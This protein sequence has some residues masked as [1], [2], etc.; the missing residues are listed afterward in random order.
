MATPTPNTI[1]TDRTGNQCMPPRAM[2]WPA[3]VDGWGAYR[4]QDLRRVSVPAHDTLVVHDVVGLRNR[5]QAAV[6]AIARKNGVSAH[7]DPVMAWAHAGGRARATR[8]PSRPFHPPARPRSSGPARTSPQSGRGISSVWPQ[9]CQARWR[10][11]TFVGLR[12]G[13]HGGSVP[14][15]A[16]VARGAQARTRHRGC[17][18]QRKS[19]VEPPAGATTTAL[20][21]AEH[22]RM[23]QVNTKQT[24]GAKRAAIPTFL[25]REA[26]NPDTLLPSYVLRPTFLFLVRLLP[27]STR[28]CFCE[29]GL[30]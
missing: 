13:R 28:A 16:D 23:G 5:S 6:T 4:G 27:A 8:L 26:A 24:A 12:A 14:G 10:A 11:S 25:K 17:L 19:A 7:A 1:R 30:E 29:G 15:T 3:G 18:C 22:A 21:R 20:G 9:R 2:R